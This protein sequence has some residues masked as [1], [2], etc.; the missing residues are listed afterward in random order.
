M[1]RNKECTFSYNIV[2][3]RIGGDL[4]SNRNENNRNLFCKF[5]L[6]IP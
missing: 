6:L 1:K 5:L 2:G 3:V 4:I